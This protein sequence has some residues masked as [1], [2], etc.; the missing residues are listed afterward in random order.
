MKSNAFNTLDI[1]VLYIKSLNNFEGCNVC[2]FYYILDA[3]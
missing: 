3:P 1:Y 2:T